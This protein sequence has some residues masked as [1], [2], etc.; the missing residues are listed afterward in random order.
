MKYLRTFLALLT[1]SVSIF[2][3]ATTE[4]ERSVST[5][6]PVVETRTYEKDGKMVTER[7][8]TTRVKEVEAVSVIQ[9]KTYKAAIFISNRA[10]AALDEKIMALEDFITAR[11][12]DLGFQVISRETVADALRA[13]DPATASGNARPEGS[14]EAKLT[15]QSSALRLSQNLGADYLIVASIASFGTN[16][17]AVD[18]YGVKGVFA[19]SNLRVTYKILDGTT[20]G[21]LT[22]DTIKVTSSSR[23]TE[24]ASED[25]EDALNELLDQASEQLAGSL[26]TRVAQRRITPATKA[27]SFVTMT[28]K[29]EAADMM[30]PDVRIGA[31]NTVTLSESKFKVSPLSVVV[32]VDGVAVGTAPGEISLKPGF[33]KLRLTREGFKPW[34][35]TI[36]AVNGQTLTVAL[37]MSAEGYARWQESTAF[38]NTLKNNAKLTDAEAQKLR[39]QAKMFEQSGYK[40]DVTVKTDKALQI[41]NTTNSIFGGPV[42]Q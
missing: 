27:A 12:T 35:R 26:K 18:A 5:Q 1:A 22:A 42:S 32:E 9:P 10:G 4:V 34:E 3:Q 19:D 8:T 15:E 21:S 11:I 14:L 7:V 2:A 29:T 33:S 39:G 23:Q 38:I 25:K 6:D 41:N 16:K 31:E 40:M 17:R 30:I 13:F 37:E 20:G 28:I 36:N 24:N